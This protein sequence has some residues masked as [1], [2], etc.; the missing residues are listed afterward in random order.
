MS[1]PAV[2]E[3][4]EVQKA[5]QAEQARVAKALRDANTVRGTAKTVRSADIST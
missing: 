5:A 3:A 2:A 4:A 1:L